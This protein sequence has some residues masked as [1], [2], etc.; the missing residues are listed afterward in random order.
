VR[1]SYFSGPNTSGGPTEY[2]VEIGSSTLIKV[3]NNIIFGITSGVLPDTSDGIVV[4]YNYAL[5][6][7]TGNEFGDFEPHAVHN[8]Y[9]LYEGNAI[10]RESV[11][12][13]WGSHS[14][15]TLFRDRSTG[16]GQNKV[17]NYRTPL[18]IAAHNRYM[19]VVG[20]VLGTIGM[21]TRYQIDNTNDSGTDDFVYELGFW[22]SWTSG[23]SQFDSVALTSLMRWGNWDS[24]T[25]TTNGNTNGVRWCAGSG[26]G[27]AACTAPE[28]A[29]TDTTFPGLASPSTT[30]PASFYLPSRP[31]WWATTWGTP[32]WPAIGPDVTCTTNCVSNA[33][34][35]AAKTP[36]QLC[37][38]NTA[39]SGGYLTNFDANAC[40]Y[41]GSSTAPAPPTGLSALVQ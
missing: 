31:S 33:A 13:V 38:E 35:H 39:K 32:P 6:T 8:Y 4:G 9:H 25:Y 20:N 36:A 3:E 26:V 16:N 37:Y 29:S 15:T 14:Q 27:N 12:N 34:S 28:T 30:L 41:S 2:G 23:T 19:N 24:A 22:N 10:D 7:A 11:D 17:S 18:F 5:N 1:D 40:Y 21:H